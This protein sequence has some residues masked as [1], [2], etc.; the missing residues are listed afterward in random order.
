MTLGFSYKFYRT[1]AEAIYGMRE[2]IFAAQESIYWEIYSLVDDEVGNMFI[3]LLCQKAQ[4]GLEVKIIVDAVGSFELS[5]VA[6]ARLRGAGVDVVSYNTLLPKL[7]LRGWV[8]SVWH[9]NHRKILV[10]DKEVVFIGG[11][12]VASNYFA[13]DDL[14]L[15]ITGRITTPLLRSFAKSYIRG[16]GDKNKVKHLLNTKLKKEWEE[17]KLRSKFILHSPINSRRS[18][19]KNIFLNALSKAHVDFNLLTPYFVPDKKFFYLVSEA[20]E[21]GVKIDLF[22]PLLPDHKILEWISGF[23]SKMAHKHGINVYMS[24]KMNHGKAMTS[25]SAV[26]FVSSVNFTNRSFF[27]NEEAGYLFSDQVMIDE[28]NLIFEDLRQKSLFLNEKNYQHFGWKGKVKDWLG[29]K[30]GDWV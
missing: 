12:N 20:K 28:L 10:I 22:L 21:R 11:V 3:D 23:Y 8:N 18:K 29:E 16:G 6:L 15:R 26:G 7:S 5:R 14:H 17:F 30:F 19:I 13:W 24:T 2:A 27:I 4:A 1:T 9:R 25:D